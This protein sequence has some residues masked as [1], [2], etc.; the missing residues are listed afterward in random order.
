MNGRVDYYLSPPHHLVYNS[1]YY[2]YKILCFMVNFSD[3]QEFTGVAVDN[4]VNSL[5]KSFQDK[6]K[7]MLSR[8]LNTFNGGQRFEINKVY[9][10]DGHPFFK[11]YSVDD[12]EGV[13]VAINLVSVDIDGEKV[14]D[15]KSLTVSLGSLCEP[16]S[17]FATLS[18]A[19]IKT[20]LTK[21][22]T[23]YIIKYSSDEAR[24]GKTRKGKAFVIHN[25][26][27]SI[28]GKYESGKFVPINGETEAKKT[29]K[30]N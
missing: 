7:E 17:D 29:T 16:N 28:V 24:A 12:T 19:D 22:F 13:Y 3:L 9:R 30:R 14:T 25:R 8:A 6:A 20:L 4:L 23:P 18:S 27:V 1:I 11:D 10:I 2:N 21:D 26:N 15:G 5:P